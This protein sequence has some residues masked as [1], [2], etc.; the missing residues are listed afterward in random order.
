MKNSTEKRDDHSKKRLPIPKKY[1]GMYS[2]KE[3]LMENIRKTVGEPDY[4]ELNRYSD[5]Q[6]IKFF[7]HEENPVKYFRCKS[8]VEEQESKQFCKGILELTQF[9]KHLHMSV[10]ER[11]K[12]CFSAEQLKYI[13]QAY[14]GLQITYDDKCVPA[15]DKLFEFLN[16]EENKILDGLD[17]EIFKS[18]LKAISSIEFDVFI[19]SILKLSKTEDVNKL[20]DY[21]KKV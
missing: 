19:N 10:K 17:K 5:S 16:S 6:I 2:A 18:E 8:A 13:F 9:R 20:I 14:D 21:L 4:K 1:Y 7:K 12:G 3:S 11:F 15:K